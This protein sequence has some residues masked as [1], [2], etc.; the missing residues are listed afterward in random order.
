LLYL[1][2]PESRVYEQ[3]YV[4]DKN[5]N[6]FLQNLGLILEEKHLKTGNFDNLKEDIINCGVIY[7]S[8]PFYELVFI[9]PTMKA[10]THAKV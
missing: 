1:A 7:H 4:Q 8:D 9:V 5:Y 6:D 3:N 2:S 10:E